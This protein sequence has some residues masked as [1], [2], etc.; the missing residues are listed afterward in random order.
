MPAID[1][2]QHSATELTGRSIIGFSRGKQGGPGFRAFDPQTGKTCEPEFTSAT[3]EEVDRAVELAVAAAPEWAKASGKVRAE[4]LRAVASGLEKIADSIIER[5]QLET[6]LPHGRFKSELART[7]GQMR[8]FADVV[9]EGSWVMAR[10]DRADPKRAPQPKPDIRSMLIPL[11]PVVVFGASNF[12]LAFS[13]GG[14]D[15]VSAWAS[16]NPVIVKAHPAHP[17]TGELVGRVIAD[18]VRSLGLPEGLFSLL[19]DS[20]V[21]VGQALVKH[22]EVKGVGFTG[23]LAGGRALMDL[24]AARPEPIPVFA[25]MGST[26]PVFI[27]PGAL[28]ERGGQIAA[29]LYGSITLG[30]GQFCTKPGIVF[31]PQGEASQDLAREVEKRVSEASPFTLLTSG[32]HKAFVRGLDERKKSAANLR[33]TAGN[34]D[35]VDGYR[36]NPAVI[37]TDVETFLSELEL[38]EELFGPATLLVSHSNKDQALEAAAKLKG[39]LT[40]TVHGTEQDFTEYADLIAILQTKVGRLVFNGYPTGVE[41]SHAMV[42]GGP[43]PATSDGRS[44]SVGTLA[45]L[46]FCRPVCFQDCPNELL[47]LELRDENP[48]QIWR[49]VDSHMTQ[50]TVV[51]PM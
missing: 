22:S 45:I 41:V 29:G 25:E 1:T 48:L 40:A 35:Q 13:V 18:T 39:H 51:G 2:T 30:G 44:T 11:G 7:C 14:G 42:H 12:P 21:T 20:G 19:F 6:G 49:M 8:L 46:R 24:A 31:L 32:I 50:E 23:S 27:L 37:Q 26:N 5:A 15:T 16:G 43:Y 17:G 36:A 4:F 47:P 10:I 3:V 38:S 33:V 28:K 9:E 34:G